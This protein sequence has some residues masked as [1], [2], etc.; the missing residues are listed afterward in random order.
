M[1]ADRYERLIRWYPSEWRARY[2]GELTALLEDSYAT[3]GD[4]PLRARVGLVRRGMAERA[5]SV[6]FIGSAPEPAQELRAGAVLVLCGWPLFLI[7]GAVFG[8]FADNWWIGT[9]AVER[10]PASASFNAAAVLGMAGCT[11][12]ALAALAAL[13]SFVRLVRAGRWSTVRRPVLRAGVAVVV[14]AVLLGGGLVWAH[15]LSPHDR[16]GGLAVYGAAFIVIGLAAFV[17]LLLAAA[18]AVAVARR[19]DVPA[20]VL[21]ALGV[22]ALLLAVVMT[23]LFAGFVTWW[24]TEAAF[25]PTVLLNGVGNGVPFTSRTVPPTLLVAGLLMVLGL[26]LAGR[27]TG[28]VARGLRHGRPAT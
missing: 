28:L 12:V 24:A 4:V 20:G 9:P 1:S 26:A 2:G 14:A 7:A 25:A 5:R 15:H 23:L 17:A 13:P 6:G 11:V 21:R 19:I 16:N 22:M 8:K 18:A 3:A 10:L 27:G